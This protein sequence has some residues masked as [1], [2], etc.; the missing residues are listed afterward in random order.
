MKRLLIL[1]SC[2]FLGLTVSFGCS[3]AKD[4][5]FPEKVEPPPGDPTSATPGA[6]SN[7]NNGGASVPKKPK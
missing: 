3:K 5:Q 6:D 7:K 1:F 4:A 2:I